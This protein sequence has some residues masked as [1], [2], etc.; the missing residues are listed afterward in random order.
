LEVSSPGLDRPLVKH[1]HFQRYRDSKVRIRTRTSHLGRRKFIG[2]L[3]EVGEESVVVDVDGE[4][5]ELPFSDMER[6]NLVGQIR[7]SSA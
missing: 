7:D 1:E 2:T 6:A 4:P 3:A 5:Y